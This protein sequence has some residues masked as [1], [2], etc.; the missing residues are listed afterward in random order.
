[1]QKVYR[2]LLNSLNSWVTLVL[3]IALS[4]VSFCQGQIAKDM[5]LFVSSGSVM[6]VFGLLSMI[7]FTTIEKYLNRK[8]IVAVSTGV[9]GPPLSKE[10]SERIQRE[11]IA[12]AEVRIRQELRTEVKGIILTIVGTLISAYGSYLPILEWFEQFT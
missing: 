8:A 9:T 4:V 12:K 7:K 11:N 10:E 5:S 3:L 6:T 1:M 2:F